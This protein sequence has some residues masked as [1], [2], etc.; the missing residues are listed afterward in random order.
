MSDIPNL[1]G[2]LPTRPLKMA[3]IG[4]ALLACTAAAGLFFLVPGGSATYLGLAVSREKTPAADWKGRGFWALSLLL[5]SGGTGLIIARFVHQKNRHR[6]DLILHSLKTVQPAGRPFRTITL[7]GKKD[8][9]SELAETINFY[10]EN[11]EKAS[12]SLKDLEQEYDRLFNQ[13]VSGNFWTSMTGEILRCNSAFARLIGYRTAKEVV[14]QSLRNL[15]PET[16]EWDK[17]VLEIQNRKKIEKPEWLVFDRNKNPRVVQGRFLGKADDQGR[18]IQI[19]GTWKDLSEVANLKESLD[20]SLLYDSLTGLLNRQSFENEMRRFDQGDYDPVGI[21][22]ID[23]NGLKYVNDAIGCEE[24]NQLLLQ[25]T[26]VLKATFPGNETIARVG[27]D[28]FA[29]LVV[30]TDREDLAEARRHIRQA[31]ERYNDSLP[32]L[33]LSLAVGFA[34]NDEHP[35]T[36]REVFTQADNN[37][38]REKLL[39]NQSIHSSVVQTLNKALEM[40]DFITEG[41]ARRIQYLVEE[42]AQAIGLSERSVIDLRLLAQFHDIGKVG[43]PDRILMKPGPLTPE[44]AIEMQKHCEIGYRIAL[45]ATDLVPIADWILKHHEWWNGH[46]YPAGLAGDRIPLECR[47]LAVADAFDVLTNDRPYRRAVPLEEAV[48]EITRY[49]G[50]QFDPFLVKK[51]RE[52]IEKK[53]DSGQEAVA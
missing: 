29:V 45:A 22:T 16:E 36:V 28:E 44:E 7:A 1:T 13:G 35:A 53:Q 5:V 31:V 11:L 4:L 8:Q 43:I 32:E 25:A 27:G 17:L 38:Y 49:S 23:V 41:H 48:E 24:G 47:I 26:R 42:M 10:L 2:P 15:L 21:L 37:M 3:L 33:P 40:R 51:F 19:L 50:I 14:G 9:V 18:I 52:L 46:G 12:G 39:C 34:L 20:R 6:I 30:R